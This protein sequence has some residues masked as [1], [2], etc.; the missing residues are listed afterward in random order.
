MYKP[1]CAYF[2]VKNP[3]SVLCPFGFPAFPGTFLGGGAGA[4]GFTVPTELLDPAWPVDPPFF[5]SFSSL[6]SVETDEARD[7]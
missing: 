3:A 5:I 7:C 1:P 2:L 6:M 4:L